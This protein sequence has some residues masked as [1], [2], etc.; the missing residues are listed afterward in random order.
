MF[1]WWWFR[2]DPLFSLWQ[3]KGGALGFLQ[4]NPSS[5]E[6]ISIDGKTPEVLL[7]YVNGDH[8]YV[9]FDPY[10][11]DAQEVSMSQKEGLGALELKGKA[12]LK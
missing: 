10:C 9:V 5:V 12:S 1:W 7:A 2:F 8:E 11:K 4:V 3:A 6:E